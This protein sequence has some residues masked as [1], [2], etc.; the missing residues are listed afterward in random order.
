[1]IPES[2]FL[3]R[4]IGKHREFLQSYGLALRDAGIQY[5]NLVNVSSIIPPGCKIISKETGK[6][7]LRPG[8]ITLAV[9]A[10]NSINEPNRLVAASIGM[11][12]PNDKSK[13]GYKVSCL[14]DINGIPLSILLNKGSHHDASFIDDHLNNL[15]ILPIK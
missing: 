15:F 12:I 6:K 13:Y 9:I 1:M 14:T 2:L 5:C 8:E 10:K 3:T 7:M 11:A 4:G